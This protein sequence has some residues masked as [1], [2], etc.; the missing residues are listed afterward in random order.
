MAQYF[1]TTFN[2]LQNK[3][4]EGLSEDTLAIFLGHDWPGNVRELE[5]AIEHAFIVCPQG[6]IL[7]EPLPDHFHPEYCASSASTLGLS[8]KDQEKRLL[9]EALERNHRRRLGTARELCIDSC[10]LRSLAWLTGTKRS[11]DTGA[12]TSGI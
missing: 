3:R 8:L 1:I 4:V 6:L 9:W 12:H 2:K 5:S 10:L 7:P 11:F